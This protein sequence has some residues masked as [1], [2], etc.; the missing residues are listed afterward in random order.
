MNRILTFYR[1]LI[2]LVLFL[3]HS[4]VSGQSV[5][6]E[7]N[8]P[9][10]AELIYQIKSSQKGIP[11]SGETKLSWQL[12][13]NNSNNKKT[14]EI[15]S[16]T[17]VALFG[18]ILAAN[19]TGNI[20]AYGLAPETFLEKRFRKAESTTRFD[21]DKHAITF[22]ESDLTYP[23]HG[24]EQDRQSA[25][26]QLIALARAGGDKIKPGHEWT[27]FVAG[28]R[29]VDPW[30]FKVLDY[31]KMK[32]ALGDVDVMHISKTPPPDAKGQKLELWL[33][34][35]HQYYPARISFNDANG[36]N[37]DQRIISIEK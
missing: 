25:T 18:K 4:L 33:A 1:H 36:D 9:P 8:F 24:G 14:Y 3:C 21:R 17:S 37:I 20:D 7:F 16:E 28:S 11:V 34:I 10:S 2:P 29:D 23:I 32:T 27:M 5:P 22:S 30:I 12:H 26:W 19:S 15:K 6:H 31:S 13:E 35:E